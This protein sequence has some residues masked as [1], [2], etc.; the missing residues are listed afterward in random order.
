MNGISFI[1]AELIGSDMEGVNLSGVQIFE[2]ELSGANLKDAELSGTALSAS[3]LDGV[4]LQ[5]ANLSGAWLNLASFVG[6]DLARANLS[7]STLFAANLTGADL[8]GANLSGA[9]LIG[10]NL[11]GVD[12]RGADLSGVEFNLP[13]P[14]DAGPDFSYQ[15][16]TG[17]ELTRALL[18]QPSLAKV[19][20]DPAETTLNETQLKPLLKDAV[21]QGVLYNDETI[22][23]LGFDI[24]PAAIFQP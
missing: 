24:P 8:M 15:N 12:L 18:S 7:G 21:L 20:N 19:A 14:E 17:D 16:L 23:P 6:S 5:G 10:A 9:G 13:L 22:W 4:N 11:S 1:R 2:A 3:I